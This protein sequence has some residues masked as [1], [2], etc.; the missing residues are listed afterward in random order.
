MR[1]KLPTLVRRALEAN[2]FWKENRL[3]L[4][5]FRHFRWIALSAIAFAFAAAL[6]E[7]ITV[8]FIASFL[9]GLT[10]PE[11]PPIRTGLA[12]FDVLFLAAE[13][14]AT[15]RIYRL[16]GL[17]LVGVWLRA[18]FDYL[19]RVYSKKASLSLVDNLR[20]R[21]FEQ[22]KSFNLSF[23]T[24]AN[25]GAL[26]STLRGE[27]KQV[28][29]AFDLLASSFIFSSKL[30]AYMVAMLLLSWQ[31]F[32][33]S[34]FVFGLLS[35]G[36][37]SLTA[38]V[39]EASFEVPKANKVF[40][41]SALSF[42][43]GIRT[44]HACGT[45]EFETRRYY[46]ATR[47]IYKAQISVIKLS[48]LVQP[49]VEG[50]GA[51]L[52]VGMVV[53]SY[54]LLILTGRLTASELLTFLFV[55]IRTTPLFSAFN[56]TLV[57]FMSAQ[58]SLSAV[59]DLLR[60]DDK[61]YFQDGH[62]TFTGLQRS[63]DFESVDFSYQPEEPVLHDITLSIKRGETTAL[64]GTSGAGKTTLA[65]LIPR[66]YDPTQGRI[67][68][69]GVDI[70]SLKID[71]FRQCM[72]IVSQDTFIFNTTVKENIAYGISDNNETSEQSLYEAARM[73]NALDF[74]LNL[75]QGF[76][77]VLGDRGIRLSGGQRQ[78]IAI[79]RALLQ[80]PEVLIL[81]EAT[82][83]LDSLTEKLI[84]DSLERLSKGRTVVAIAHRLSTI[85]NADKV[86]VLEKGRI[87]EQG[88]YQDL[89]ETRGKLW[90]Y[91]KMQFEMSNT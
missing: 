42:V 48:E 7:G 26:I 89:L 2:S 44:V 23:Y 1:M 12:W 16:S 11:E 19:S 79:A 53:V 17:L 9:Q 40:T 39:R 78:R 38:R 58:G 59:N 41:S 85:A 65:D 63:I 47:E 60:R 10:N 6:L 72:A 32:L 50:A 88:R 83:A 31:L 70:R 18:V 57:S 81:D 24:T 37:T 36:L 22:L 15:E 14:S 27:V 74:I 71:S 8:G 33:T 91:H 68:V 3:I 67:L 62:K 5:E 4:Q 87:V 86:V 76:D 82:S 13:A 77:T 35:V 45:Q 84:Q 90:E 29:Q 55:L 73:A 20:R 28:Q 66:F 49:I 61:P 69:D 21:I 75:P 56:G 80:N 52:L 25:P 34:V 43:S 51:T 30:L 64:V 54:G 46:K